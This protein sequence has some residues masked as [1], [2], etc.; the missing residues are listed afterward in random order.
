MTAEAMTPVAARPSRVQRITRIAGIVIAVL[1]VLLS[2]IIW[3]ANRN[4]LPGC[5]SR[6]A[7][8]TLSNVFKSN[9]LKPTRYDEIKT[10]AKS[11]DEVRCSATL[12]LSEGGQVRV[13]YRFFWQD[14]AAKIEYR[15]IR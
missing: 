15:L 8:D 12:P 13:D 2:A 7:K 1:G 4:T 5:D 9:K 14:S 10:L 3:L 11:E 6:R